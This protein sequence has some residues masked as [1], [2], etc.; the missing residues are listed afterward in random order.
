LHA[1]GGGSYWFRS[2]RGFHTSLN[3]SLASLESL[4]DELGDADIEIKRAVNSC[5]RRLSNM[6]G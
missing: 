6:L 1:D 3:E 2:S 5:Y 4:I